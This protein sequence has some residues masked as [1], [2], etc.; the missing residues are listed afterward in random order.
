MTQYTSHQI[1]LKS[2]PVGMPDEGNFETLAVDVP[3]PVAGEVLVRNLWMSVDP[4]M[5]G[6]MIER[7]SYVPPFQ[8]GQ[9][10]QGGAVGEVLESA[11]P[12][13][14]PGD[15]VL[16]MHGWREMFV[17]PA[18]ELTP[19]DGTLAPLQAYLGVMGMPGMTAYAGLLRIGEP[20]AGETV[21]VSA[22]SGAVGALVCQIAL[23]KGCRVVGSVGSD[24]K[25]AWLRELGVH[26]VINYKTC[27]DLQAALMAAAPQGVDV[28]FENVGGEHLRAA[29]EA[30][31]PFGR[32]VVCGM[33]S[34][35]NDV[36]R[37]PGP[38]NLFNIIGK[39]LRMQGFIV[40][41]LWDMHGQFLKDMA[42]WIPAGKL[43]WK[44]TVEEGVER[45][46]Q[47]FI[48]LFTGD[49]FGKMLVKL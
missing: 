38:D 8:I 25:A 26:E 45:A 3:P 49:N 28:Y 16:S 39:N 44:E 32:I 5:R 36:T 31:N 27:G 21:F 34:G 40:T 33:I 43:Q 29:L 35:Y 23:I 24:E 6:R 1:H 20:K 30:M 10:L 12:D 42:S 46:P 4:Y 13:L 17:A 41:Q 19:V 48:N 37:T 2:R 11:S 22:A 14:K 18:G 47:A 9:V 15:H 7:K